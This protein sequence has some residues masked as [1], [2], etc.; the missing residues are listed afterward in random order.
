MPAHT[1][2]SLTRAT[3][4]LLNAFSSGADTPT[5]L[6]TFTANP[7]PQILEHGLRQLAPFLDRPFTGQ[8]EVKQYFTILNEH[9]GI[10]SVD[11]DDESFWV[12]DTE[13][14]VVCLRGNARFVS[15]RTGQKWDEVFIYRIEIAEEGKED[16]EGRAELKV[17]KYEVWADTGAAYL[18]MRGELEGLKA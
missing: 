11:L 8:S 9:L 4:S 7:A 1:R 15:K 13:T 3:Q 5:L 14:M 12:V 18:A 17:R 16:A 6:S 2:Q 10:E